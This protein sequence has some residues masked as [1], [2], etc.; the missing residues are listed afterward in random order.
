[1]SLRL[2]R[3]FR[4]TDNPADVTVEVRKTVRVRSPGFTDEEAKVIL[5]AALEAPHGFGK[6]IEDNKRAIRWGPWVCA[7]TGARITEVMQFR[8]QDVGTHDNIPCL[9]ITPEA[10]STKTGKQRLVPIHPHVVEM[11]FLDFAGPP[12]RPP[13]LHAEVGGQPRDP[14]RKRR[15]ESKRLGSHDGRHQRS[16]GATQSRMA[17]QVQTEARKLSIERWIADAIQGHE[18]GTA[19]AN[20]GEVPISPLYEAIVRITRHEGP[21][22]RLSD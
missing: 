2:K 13:V 8:K 4:I 17:P 5:P 18:D 19:S 21:V 20:Y 3:K 16:A 9:W 10:G 22:L 6:M 1:M 14:R 12:R 11:G 15:Q 7:Y